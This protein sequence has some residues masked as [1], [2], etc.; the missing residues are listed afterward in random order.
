MDLLA[1]NIVNFKFYIPKD[2]SKD[3]LEV[4]LSMANDLGTKDRF[5]N[6]SYIVSFDDP[7]KANKENQIIIGDISKLTIKEEKILK[8]VGEDDGLIYLN[9]FK[10]NLQLY[11][12][13]RGNGIRKAL[14][15]VLTPS[16]VSLTE[17]NPVIVKSTV[18]REKA[19]EDLKGVIRLKDL[20]YQNVVI[21]GSFHQSTSLCNCS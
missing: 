3:E 7:Y 13:G 8:E 14:N 5:K 6:L 12:S 10:D 19:V 4:L 1:Q 18:E 2:F 16:Q 17:K 15:Y 9:N 20:G 11:I 21:S